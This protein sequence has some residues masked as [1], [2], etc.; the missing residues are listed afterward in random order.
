VSVSASVRGMGWDG[1][2]SQCS[3]CVVSD[4]DGSGERGSDRGRGGGG[5][6]EGAREE[7][8]SGSAEDKKE[9]LFPRT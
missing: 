7:T 9:L 5:R 2:G 4:D 3:S 1:M 6:G 8:A